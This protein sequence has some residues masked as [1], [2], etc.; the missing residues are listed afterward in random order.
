MIANPLDPVGRAGPLGRRAIPRGIK[1]A[2]EHM[3]AS[4]RP[5]MTMGELVRVCGV[6]ERTLYKHFRAFIGLSP[7]AYWRRLR[8][9]AARECLLSGAEGESVSAVAIRHGFEHFGR[10]ST[11]YSRC[12][13]EPP[14]A[15]LRCARTSALCA[16]GQ[17]AS[18]TGSRQ[19]H[20]Q[21]CPARGKPSVAILPC[22]VSA[23]EQQHRFFAE[24][25]AEGIATALSRVRSISVVAPRSAPSHAL[26][27]AQRLAR[28]A[29]A[30]YL[31]TGRIAENGERVRVLIRLLE[32]ATGH[33]IWGDSYDGG[34]NELLGLQDRVTEG[35]I[36]AILPNVRGAEIERARR[37]PPQDLDAY[38]LTM[39]AFPFVFAANPDATR[40]ALELLDRAME[41]DPDYALASAL[42]AWCHAQL[43][44][45]NGT[46][47]LAQEKT[48]A[49]QL[50]QR[51]A[52]LDSEDPLVLT[53]RCAVHTMAREFDAADVL[54]ARA[55][56]LD[57]TSGWAWE[58]SGWLN[59]YV[60]K[61]Q[62]AIEHFG[63]AIQCDPSSASN[64]NRFIGIGSAHFDAG[65]YDAAA[66]RMRKALLEQPGTGWVNRTLAVSY[67]RLGE[68]WSAFDALEAFRRYC[69]DITVS[70]VVG[71]LPFT[72]DFLDRVGEG[73]SDLGLAP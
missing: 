66:L 54:L 9:S 20:I 13:G 11:Q 27:D 53:A 62:T 21:A 7:L 40:R 46:H 68:R 48:W 36:K 69:P 34:I 33:H 44:M 49:L 35:V 4:P 8:L 31:L 58:R 10:F 14:S 42:A 70:R 65:D 59:T 41:I 12:F 37:T 57:P 15:T 63:R 28:E 5:K 23:A 38:A 64:A 39:R 72:R 26:L 43:V 52:I 61:P 60:G 51:A 71:A 32:T 1:K 18:A 55:V 67:S 3:R 6:P 56:A 30:R 22:L 73:L 29:G 50:A 17:R 24:C 16:I 19:A 45:H 25:V 2:I 47:A